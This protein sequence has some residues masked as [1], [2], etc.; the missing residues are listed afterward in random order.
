MLDLQLSAS[1]VKELKKAID[2]GIGINLSLGI[3]GQVTVSGGGFDP[4]PNLF[5][6]PDDFGAA[7]WQESAG[8]T[9]T[10][11]TP[12]DTALLAF[13]S[14]DRVIFDRAPSTSGTAN[15]T[16]AVAFEVRSTTGTDQHFRLVCTHSSVEDYRSV[17]LTATPDW[18]EFY[19]QQE[20][21]AG[22]G[23][24]NVLGGI[25]TSVG[26]A[27]ASLEIRSARMGEIS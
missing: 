13:T 25:S 2:M 11:G 24:G 22:A 23:D 17:D 14:G 21:G 1:A 3:G 19:F 15:R 9:L 18:Q 8:A 10:P 4:S 16:F 26:G 20:F 27:A 5:R 6:N 7:T 12:P